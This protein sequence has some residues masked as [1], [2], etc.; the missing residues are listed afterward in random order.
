MY[1]ENKYQFFVLLI[2]LLLHLYVASCWRVW[3][4]TS[5]FSI[6]VFIDFYAVIALLLMFLLKDVKSRK[7]L[8]YVMYPLISLLILLNLFQ[9]YQQRIWVFPLEYVS[10]DIYWD[11]F[12]RTVP[13]ARATIDEKH[14]EYV[15]T[16]S[17]DFE[18]NLGWNNEHTLINLDGNTV[19]EISDTFSYS[20]GFKDMYSGYFTT[21]KQA[22]KISA[23]IFSDQKYS[24]SSLVVE[25]LFNEINYSYNPLYLKKYNKKEKWIPVEFAFYTPELF[26]SDD[27]VKVYF[28]N[29]SE[30]EVF[31][32]DNLKIEFISLHENTEYIEH[33]KTPQIKPL[34][35]KIINQSFE[36][37]DGGLN[38]PALS[39]EKS[40][41]GTSSSKIDI[42]QPFSVALEQTIDTLIYPGDSY[43]V[44]KAMVFSEDPV[45]ET[46]LI[47]DFIN[48]DNS[49]SYN[50]FYV[51]DKIMPGT[52]S[53]IE[54]IYPVK[55]IKS[56]NDIIKIYF[57]NPSTTET[58][59]IDDLK[60]EFITI[61]NEEDQLFVF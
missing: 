13:V 43:V 17:N 52:W 31:M 10:K 15:H 8:K 37:D 32:V 4:F 57:W 18:K 9:A 3:H 38:A 39:K 28:Y 26:T 22:I 53:N 48:K 41:N 46:R 42:E 23:D 20:A 14:I 34:D 7:F 33:I 45:A 58:V 59:Y 54:Y 44:V 50:P 19:S 56:F 40:F 2:I 6:R 47:I 35:R 49:Y 27:Q 5:K 16:V 51:E 61:L 1:K 21:E 30:D 12:G 25:F 11:S 24:G 29:N 60:I 55:E 36:D